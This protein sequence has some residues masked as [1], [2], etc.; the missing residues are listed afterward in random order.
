MSLG[1]LKAK[2]SSKTVGIAE[3]RRRRA[4]SPMEK[5]K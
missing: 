3:E 1:S 5:N 2:L 4:H